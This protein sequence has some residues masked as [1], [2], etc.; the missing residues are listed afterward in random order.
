M[1]GVTNITLEL[2][3]AKWTDSDD[4]AEVS[5]C[6]ARNCTEI[7]SVPGKIDPL[8]DIFGN[9]STLGLVQKQTGTLT[10]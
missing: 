4:K 1:Y 3:R 9:S 2:E 5:T 10:V 6:D 8:R 7:V